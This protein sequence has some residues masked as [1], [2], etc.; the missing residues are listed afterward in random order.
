M[1]CGTT[2]KISLKAV[3]D[4]E[5]E[6]QRQRE[7]DRRQLI[8]VLVEVQKEDAIE[9]EEVKEGMVPSLEKQSLGGKLLRIWSQ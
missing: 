8:D 7:V 1:A 4:L 3:Q 6:D 9:L 2:Q 5:E